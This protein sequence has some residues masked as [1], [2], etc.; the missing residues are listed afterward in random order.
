MD[1]GHETKN[2]P[3][4]KQD[5]NESHA[6]P[7]QYE[8]KP[9]MGF[10]E[11]IRRIE[12]SITSLKDEMLVM[13]KTV[14]N[15]ANNVDT[16]KN[17]ILLE[18][19]KTAREHYGHSN[20]LNLN[21]I[22]DVK[23]EMKSASPYI[24]QDTMDDDDT[25]CAKKESKI[26]STS[27]VQDKIKQDDTEH[28]KEV[29]K[30]VS[31]EEDCSVHIAGQTQSNKKPGS[32]TPLSHNVD[33]DMM[34]LTFPHN[35]RL[36]ASSVTPSSKP[37]VTRSQKRSPIVT[38]QSEVPKVNKRQKIKDSSQESRLDDDEDMN[39]FEPFTEME[40]II[41]NYIF[42]KNFEES[43]VL[44]SMKYEYGDRAAFN[45]LL[46][47]QWISSQIINLFVCKMRME[48]NKYRDMFVW[49]LP[50]HFAQK[51]LE[52]DGNP[53]LEWFKKTYRDDDKYMSNLVKCERESWSKHLRYKL[54]ASLVL[55]KNND[56]RSR[57]VEIAR[58]IPLQ[59]YFRSLK[60]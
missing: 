10:D 28:I 24:I 57:I 26:E 2:I 25:V 39:E 31:M 58:N 18:L 60:D 43:E 17:D 52:E 40:K 35:V 56:Q 51:M 8:H 54:A 55:S 46:P 36:N 12:Q 49:Y 21:D 1:G 45:T 59:E 33:V 3:L 37:K 48:E 41:C 9:N 50:T 42:N 13:Q 27:P 22:V 20:D 38:S 32:K 53:T 47:N 23:K 5:I 4:A 15:I 7:S 30:I 11:A 16:F 34:Q 6:M 29:S 19:K 44:V 14:T